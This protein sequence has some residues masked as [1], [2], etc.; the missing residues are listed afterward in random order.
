MKL[1]VI[2][3]V[4]T[5]TIVL[6]TIT[7]AASLDLPLNWIFVLTCIGQIFLLFMVIR[8]LKDNY[9]T[10]KTFDDYYED[11]PIGKVQNYR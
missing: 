2:F 5:T 1:P 10:E 7:I 8:V 9:S 11:H 3:Y 6:I 4:A